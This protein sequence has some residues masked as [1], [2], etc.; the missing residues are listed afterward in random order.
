MIPV[1]PRGRT[2]A[3]AAAL[4][5]WAVLPRASSAQPLTL[6]AAADAALATHPTVLAAGA[7]MDA[8]D[9]ARRAVR[10]AFLPSLVAGG[11]VTR[12]EEPMV[13]A[14]LHG[15]DPRNPPAFDRTL[16]QSRLAMEVTLL[17]FGA[18]R[19]Q[20]RGAEAAEEGVG[21][22]RDATAQELLENVAATYTGVLAAR[23][24]REAARRQRDALAA[25]LDRAEQ[26]LR[27]GTAA[28]VEV[29]RAEAALLDA[30]AQLATAEARTG[31]AERAL[32][33]LMGVDPESL[34]GR[35]M[36]SVAPRAAPTEPPVAT[37]AV[38][39]RIEAARRS[40]EGARARLSQERA[41]RLPTLRGSAGL[42][43]FGSAAGDYVTEWQAGLRFSW[44]L[45]TG[46]ARTAA[47]A[48]AR[49]DLRVAEE[50]LRQ[51]ELAVAASFDAADAA[52]AEARARGQA[53]QASVA[54]WDE[55]TRIEKLSLETGSGVQ[56]D[57]LRAEAALYQA[58]AGYAR[59]RFDEILALVG[60]ARAQGI[61]DRG[62]LDVRLETR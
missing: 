24:M 9:A 53:L 44:P 32:A 31:L 13:V 43:N 6:G 42:L 62:W 58:R 28:R 1:T 47:V 37:L 12:Y 55:V 39:P 46:G 15:F 49:A 7:R 20:L 14:P 22:R 2:G 38:D 52:L 18:R 5:L 3:L 56:Q 45:F 50:E 17:D 11:A 27:E 23:E 10:A 34:S 35:E 8:A 41:G 21:L 26:R 4:V 48:R 16:L 57:Y 25:E 60:R 30:R 29:L 33:R 59:A 40:V 51:A 19:A 61:L 36:A 54:Q